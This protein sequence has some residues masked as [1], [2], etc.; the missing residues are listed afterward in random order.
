M[1]ADDDLGPLSTGYAFG[2]LVESWLEM[3]AASP[4]LEL[5]TFIGLLDGKPV[6]FACCTPQPFARDGY[7]VGAVHVLAEHRRQ[8][9]GGALRAAVHRVVR[10]RAPGI[11]W[12]HDADEPD[13]V[14]AA[15]A[16]GLTRVGEH[17]ESFLDLTALDRA[18]F[19]QLGRVDGVR[20]APVEGLDEGGWQ[21]L[22][23]SSNA[24]AKDAP[25][26]DQ[27]TEDLPLDSFRAM[28]DQPW[29]M[30]TAEEEGR[31][32]GLTFVVHR[33]GGEPTCNTWFT[34]VAPEARGRGLATAMKAR[35]ALVM[36][37]AGVERL[38]TQN[39]EGNEPIL[40]ANARLGFQP[41]L[42]YFDVTEA[43]S[44]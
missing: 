11:M 1:A 28:L 3:A 31:L 6:G 22:W 32:L 43:L 9:V 44:S 2:W 35:Q 30:L 20:L 24:W 23:A 25:D 33:P 18:C 13:A 37:D 38:Y 39:M 16:W 7:G 42:R 26:N 29:M 5:Y 36:A 14:A 40:R 12:Q 17:Q 34:G 4:D 41:C 27:G 10:D 8:G 15:E 19:E 21:T